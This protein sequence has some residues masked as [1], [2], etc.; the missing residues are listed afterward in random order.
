MP[1]FQLIVLSLLV[2]FSPQ[3]ADNLVANGGFENGFIGWT[4]WGQNA[5]LIT[6]NHEQPHSGTNSAR[7]QRG[8]NA[9]YF[10]HPLNPQQ[11]YELHFAYRLTGGNPSGQVSLGFSKEGGPLRSAGSQVFK[12]APPS[13]P[14]ANEWAERA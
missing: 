4:R 8:H 13:G 12:L 7:I 6:L 3:A 11:A 2:A 9:L 10:S 5:A 1:L 14:D